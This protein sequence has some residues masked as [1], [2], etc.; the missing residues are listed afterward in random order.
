MKKKQRGGIKL[1]CQEIVNAV[2]TS[3]NT[4]LRTPASI[5]YG[6]SSKGVKNWTLTSF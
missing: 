2:P 4:R 1:I 3:I 5:A 6:T